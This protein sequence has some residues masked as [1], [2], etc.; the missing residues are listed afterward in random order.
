MNSW[1]DMVTLMMNLVNDSCNPT[2]NGEW[3]IIRA[4][5]VEIC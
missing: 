4:A 1:W 5:V 3:F 2:A